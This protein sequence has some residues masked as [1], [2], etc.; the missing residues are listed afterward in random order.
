MAKIKH[1]FTG[2]RLVV[3]PFYCVDKALNDPLI[4][5]LVIH[6]MGFFPMAEGHYIDRPYG[7]G[8]Y[9]L[10]YCTQGEGW[11]VINNTKH[12][13]TENSFFFIP[14]EQTHQYGS[15]EDHPWSIY[16]A[17]FK[18]YKAQFI[19]K[20]TQGI[21]TLNIE[22][23]SRI[24]DRIAQF[25]ELLNVLESSIDDC[26]TNYV[27]MSFHH[28]ISSF[29]YVQA[30]HEAKFSRNKAANTFFISKA[31]HYM[32]E[33]IEK[34]LTLRNIADYLGYSE[35]HIYRLFLKETKYTP[36]N[37][38]NQLKIERSCQFLRNT[39][40][41]I[42]QI[43]FKMGFDDPYYFSRLFK[44]NV[45]LSPKVYRLQASSQ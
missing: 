5:D 45:G 29:L 14:K 42:N 8:E 10:I 6:S 32:Y 3:L 12:I 28:L 30:Y 18:G 44:K 11:Y 22:K 37:Y 4:S 21:V 15:S 13:V 1:G 9:I 40:M 16:W 24:E 41:K 7:C 23:N 20:K 33:N 35:T 19:S 26:S 17:H 2:Q 43:A 39:N 31:T 25:D 27:N 38:F 36:I 34:K